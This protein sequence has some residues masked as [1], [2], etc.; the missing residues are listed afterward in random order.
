VAGTGSGALPVTLTP[1]APTAGLHPGGDAD[2]VVTVTNP[3][4][5]PVSI[6]SLV[7]DTTQGTGGFAVDESHA[8]CAVSTFGYATQ[9]NAGAGWTVPAGTGSVDGTMPIT[10]S[11]A[12]TMSPSA[13]DACQGAVVTVYLRAA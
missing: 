2:V 5:T 7:L 1:A 9:S 4:S 13:A 3:N 8:G 6:G 10:L 11:R 12:L